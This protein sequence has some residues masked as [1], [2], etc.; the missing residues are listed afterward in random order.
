MDAPFIGGRATDKAL[1]A[2]E[3]SGRFKKHH[4]KLGGRKAGTPNLLSPDY[5]KLL[6]EAAHRIGSDGDGKN[7]VVG[8]FQWV[9]RYHPRVF[10]KLL[11]RIVDLENNLGEMPDE[12]CRTT[13]EFKGSYFTYVELSNTQPNAGPPNAAQAD[14]RPSSTVHMAGRRRAKSS[15]RDWDWTGLDD[16]TGEMMRLAVEK[17]KLFCKLLG[18]AFLSVPKN[19]RRTWPQGEMPN[20]DWLG[21]FPRNRPID[22][23]RYA[24]N[25]RWNFGSFEHYFSEDGTCSRVFPFSASAWRQ[26]NSDVSGNHQQAEACIHN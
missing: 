25:S 2:Q 9:A 26:G 23:G 14:S 8:Y 20:E 12:P 4:A 19:K 24:N 22:E 16:E 3:R 1:D 7:G 13:E 5:K 6:L 17:P 15:Q 10:A 11:G 18:Q 21:R